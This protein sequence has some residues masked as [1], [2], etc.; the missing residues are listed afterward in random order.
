MNKNI[1]F[2]VLIFFSFSMVLDLTGKNIPTV[3]FN[4]VENIINKQ[5]DTTY[6]V[7]FWATWCIPCRTEIP[8][9]EQINEKYTKEKFRVV[10]ISLDFPSKKEALL[11]P[12]VNENIR[13]EVWLLDERDPNSWIDKVDKSWT[14]AIPATII[15]NR[16]IKLF[17]EKS[18]DFEEL[19][20]I[21]NNCIIH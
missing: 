16:N 17:Y 15:F 2:I 18:F 3:N 11:I 14:G 12:Y 6:L 9:I 21:I 20:S 19:D 1:V 8:Y 10:L 5:N 13:S 4:R 7:N